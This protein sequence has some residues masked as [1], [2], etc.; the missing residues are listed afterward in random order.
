MDLVAFALAESSMVVGG[1]ASPF[2][3]MTA[4]ALISVVVML[5]FRAV[6]R[7]AEASDPLTGLFERPTFEASASEVIQ[8]QPRK[9]VKSLAKTAVLSGRIDHS[10]QIRQ[11]WG[12][13]TRAEAIEQ[14]AQVMR[15]G[16]RGTDTVTRADGEGIMIV[17]KGA[18]EHEAGAI[19]QRLMRTLAQTPVPG[20]DES[21]RLTASFGVAERL[22]GESD[23]DLRA[24]AQAALNA[25]Q[26]H[27]EDRIV[28]ASDWEEVKF[29]PAPDP[30]PAIP[31]AS[32]D[33]DSKDAAAA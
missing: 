19:A 10:A 4:I 29:L 7:R 28:V 20:L 22:S 9:P 2:M 31:A 23:D 27:G 32:R 33:T 13:D 17:A 14:V 26:E 30:A 8:H 18:S 11:V 16:V 25:A 1:E 15:A 12:R 3:L 6:A 5:C 24:R 21:L